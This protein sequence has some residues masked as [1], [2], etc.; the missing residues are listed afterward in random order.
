[1]KNTLCQMFIN[2]VER[3]GGQPA[4]KGRD[5]DGWEA[6]TFQELYNRVLALATALVRRGVQPRTTVGLVSDNRLEWIICDLACLMAGAADVP[7]G[8]DTTVPELTYIL[9]H[10][11]STAAFVE[12]EAQLAKVMSIPGLVDSYL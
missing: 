11:D 9:R 2:T 12:N 1:M 6:V 8:S 4:F 5:G 10:S 3:F 7:R